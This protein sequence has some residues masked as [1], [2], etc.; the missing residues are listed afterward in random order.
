MGCIWIHGTD[1]NDPFPKEDVASN[2]TLAHGTMSQAFTAVSDNEYG[3][4]LAYNA[5]I[6]C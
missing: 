3:D 2:G 4:T 6:I 1:D 5:K